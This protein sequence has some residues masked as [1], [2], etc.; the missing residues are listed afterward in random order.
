MKSIRAL[1]SI[2]SVGRCLIPYEF[3]FRFHLARCWMALPLALFVVVKCGRFVESLR[4]CNSH[5]GSTTT[6]YGHLHIVNQLPSDKY[7][8]RMGVDWCAFV[9]ERKS[10]IFVHRPCHRC[11]ICTVSRQYALAHDLFGIEKMLCFSRS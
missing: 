11:C 6:L 10:M 4:I 9:D 2:S 3:I 8:I 7:R 1:T 5:F